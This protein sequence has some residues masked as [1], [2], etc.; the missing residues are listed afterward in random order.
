MILLCFA[1]PRFI[2]FFFF[3]KKQNLAR[4]CRWNA[5]VKS[6]LNFNTR[7]FAQIKMDPEQPEEST[8]PQEG[9]EKQPEPGF[10]AS[11]KMIRTAD[12]LG[13]K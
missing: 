2:N 4:V 9:A 8:Q 12:L 3:N 1:K 6:K 10:D 5:R 11:G 13:L 7:L